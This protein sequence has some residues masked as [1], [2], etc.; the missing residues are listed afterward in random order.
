MGRQMMSRTEIYNLAKRF[1]PSIDQAI[2][3]GAFDND[4]DFMGFPSGRCGYTSELL[5]KWLHE[6]GVETLYMSGQYGY[7]WNSQNHAWLETYD[8]LVIDIT[9]DQF[10]HRR[11]KLYSNDKVYVG[12][13]DT[14]R[15]A[16]RLD[17]PVPGYVER[18]QMKLMGET[19]LQ[20]DFRRRYEIISQYL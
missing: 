6:N 11:G 2:T 16:F 17:K 19:K 13:Q 15:N 7:G 10:K 9:R 18:N 1:R 12:E 20:Q 3:D 4:S 8:G 14:F 5:A